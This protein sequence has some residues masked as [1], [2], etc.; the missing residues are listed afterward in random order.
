MS[1]ATQELIKT[2][3]QD[4]TKDIKRSIFEHMKGEPMLHV[5]NQNHPTLTS[6][7]LFF[8]FGYQIVEE[9]GPVSFLILYMNTLYYT[10]F[11]VFFPTKT[12]IH[13]GDLRLSQDIEYHCLF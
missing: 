8:Y 2:Y 1:S 5:L 4:P 6:L 7:P 11:I 3:F 13:C 9:I 12:Y 10:L